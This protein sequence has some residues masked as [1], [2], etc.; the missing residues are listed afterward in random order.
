[1]KGKRQDISKACDIA[2]MCYCLCYCFAFLLV[3][4]T[5]Q[6]IKIAGLGPDEVNEFF[7]F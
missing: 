6:C 7:K 1:M 5:V 2:K 3:Y 4:W